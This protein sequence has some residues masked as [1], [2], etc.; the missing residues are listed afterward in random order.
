M[1]QG[2]LLSPEQY[3]QVRAIVLQV[4]SEIAPEF[5]A[6]DGIESREVRE[7][8]EGILDDSVPGTGASEAT[9]SVY[10]VSEGGSWTD[11]G[12]DIEVSWPSNFGLTI[13]ASKYLRAEWINGE[14]RPATGICS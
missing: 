11:S 3:E 9:L 6:R 12:E 8:V 4:L 7:H 5:V 2:V 13:P 14:W 10:Y 1:S